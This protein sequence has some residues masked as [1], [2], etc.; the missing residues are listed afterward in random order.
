[1]FYRKVHAKRTDI[2]KQVKKNKQDKNVFE[3]EIDRLEKSI[4]IFRKQYLNDEDS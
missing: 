1:M 4:K 2:E 3:K